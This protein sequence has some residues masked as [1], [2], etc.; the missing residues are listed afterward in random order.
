MRPGGRAEGGSPWDGVGASSCPPRHLPLP[1]EGARRTGGTRFRG[2]PDASHGTRTGQVA[3]AHHRALWCLYQP[4]SPGVGH[5]PARGP[6]HRLW[7]WG[8]PVRC[9]LPP[10]PLPASSFSPPVGSFV[11]G[12]S[13]LPFTRGIRRLPSPAGT[14]RGSGGCREGGYRGGYHAPPF[15]FRSSPSIRNRN[16]PPS[17]AFPP[18]SSPQ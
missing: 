9:R 16:T 6:P 12:R 8:T 13:P 1:P 3:C 15:P 14:T 11:P 7:Q 4:G 10:T 17:T 5:P 2:C 18:F